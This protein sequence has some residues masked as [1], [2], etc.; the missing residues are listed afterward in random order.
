[1]MKKYFLIA[2]SG[3]FVFAGVVSAV[4][5]KAA[6]QQEVEVDGKK[7]VASLHQDAE[8]VQSWLDKAKQ[9][10]EPTKVSELDKR[11]IELRALLSVIDALMT[12]KNKEQFDMQGFSSANNRFNNT[13]READA[14]A[15][16]D[17]AS[18]LA[19]KKVDD[20]ALLHTPANES[21]GIYTAG[22]FS[23]E[24]KEEDQYEQRVS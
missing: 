11:L 13:Y 6:A 4:P 9:N 10:Q 14:I 16:L 2:V 12:V 8:K 7:Y 17:E 3:V 18:L 22:L 21:Q 19:M 24:E 23:S 1:M 5:E 20:D 15:Q